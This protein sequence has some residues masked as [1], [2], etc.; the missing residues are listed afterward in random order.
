MRPS[1]GLATA[2]APASVCI[3]IK[4]MAWRTWPATS[5][6]CPCS[7]R[8]S[9]VATFNTIRRVCM[10][11]HIYHVA[12][13]LPVVNVLCACMFIYL[14]ARVR[15]YISFFAWVHVSRS[16]VC[17]CNRSWYA[18]IGTDW[19]HIHDIPKAVLVT[20]Q[21]APRRPAQYITQHPHVST[22]LSTCTYNTYDCMYI[23]IYTYTY[24][25]IEMYTYI[26]M[27]ACWCTRKDVSYI[28]LKLIFIID[29]FKNTHTHIYTNTMNIF[30]CIHMYTCTCLHIIIII[31][32]CGNIRTHTHIWKYTH[33]HTLT[34]LD[35]NINICWD[36]HTYHDMYVYIYI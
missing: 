2:P 16:C 31:N 26:N 20:S 23:H 21:Q 34:Q 22:W 18:Q 29:T 27:K 13:R 6:I 11:A 10:Y 3:H 36:I 1:A 28:H 19:R 9:R 24:E 35:I 25:Y 30:L 12:W 5:R 8:E 33:T 15:M 4:K 7:A 17:A 14:Q 32:T